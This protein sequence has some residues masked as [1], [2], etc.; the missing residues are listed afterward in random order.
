M[1]IN[2][3]F[4]TSLLAFTVLGVLA[5]SLS[6]FFPSSRSEAPTEVTLSDRAQNAFAWA[7]S[8]GII[9]GRDGKLA[10]GEI[11]PAPKPPPSWQGSIY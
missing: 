10:A 9:D 5:V 8:R 4:F 11:A 6:L 7:I 2:K 3:Q 1:K